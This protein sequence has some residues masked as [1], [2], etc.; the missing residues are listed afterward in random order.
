MKIEGINTPKQITE[1]AKMLF[2]EE[3]NEKKAGRLVYH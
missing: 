1:K 3:H 2:Q